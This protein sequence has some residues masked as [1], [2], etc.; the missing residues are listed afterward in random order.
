MIR[1]LRDWLRRATLSRQGQRPG[2]GESSADSA[3]SAVP[4]PHLLLLAGRTVAG[5]VVPGVS[6]LLTQRSHGQRVEDLLA[7]I[8]KN[9]GKK[10]AGVKVPT[11]SHP[12]TKEDLTRRST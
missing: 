2:V 1:A 7:M 10:L 4:A 11:V 6:G 3:P 12:I 5:P 9:S 8:G